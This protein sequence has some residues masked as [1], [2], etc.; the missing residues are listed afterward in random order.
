MTTN[1]HQISRFCTWYNNNQKAFLNM[2]FWF[3]KKWNKIKIKKKK[4]CYSLKNENHMWNNEIYRRCSGKI[5]TG[6]TRWSKNKTLFNLYPICNF[7]E[8]AQFRNTYCITVPYWCVQHF[9]NLIVNNYC[10]Q[11]ISF[12]RV[13]YDVSPI[14]STPLLHHAFGIYQW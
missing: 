1:L 5:Q 11:L 7:Q 8:I 10:K 4:K 9:L 12:C 6:T 14:G 13:Y 3:A 2:K